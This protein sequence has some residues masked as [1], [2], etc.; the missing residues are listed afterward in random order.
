VGVLRGNQDSSKLD[1]R[2]QLLPM[3]P[4]EQWVSGIRRAEL[5]AE[6]KARSF[7]RS[8]K[9]GRG[10]P[11]CGCINSGP[12][13]YFSVRIFTVIAGVSVR[14]QGSVFE[15]FDNRLFLNRNS[16]L[17]QAVGG[18]SGQAVRKNDRFHAPQFC[19]LRQPA[20]QCLFRNQSNC[21]G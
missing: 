9:S 13:T 20:L 2:A 3:G 14:I 17:C 5:A 21:D 8:R 15:R 7:A 11:Q 19:R 12:T 6:L 18:S 1:K 4:R 16:P 10:R